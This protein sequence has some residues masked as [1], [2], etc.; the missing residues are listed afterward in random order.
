[1][2]AGNKETQA[3]I[4][5]RMRGIVSWLGAAPGLALLLG[6]AASAR[7]QF[8]TDAL[9][10]CAVSSSS[11]NGWFQSGAAGSGGLVMPANSVTF[12]NPANNNC[13]FYQWAERM[14]LWVTSPSPAGSPFGNGAAAN[15]IVFDSPTFYDVSPPDANGNRTLVGHPFT[16]ETFRFVEPRARKV[17]P[18]GL[19]I[20]KS[21]RGQ[22]L[23]LE[24]PRKGPAGKPLITDVSGKPVE[25]AQVRVAGSEV[26]LFDASGKAISLR[27]KTSPS[28]IAGHF[29]RVMSLGTICT[30]GA[31]CGGAGTGPVKGVIDVET[32]SII[33]TDTDQA[34]EG[35][36]IYPVVMTQNGSL[37]YYSI[38]VNDVFVN[39]L[40]G[41]NSHGIAP[42]PT[43]FPTT[44]PELNAITT[45]A[46]S[47]KQ[48]LADATA[49][50]VELKA[51]WVE[52]STLP[53]GAVANYI[54]TQASVPTY[55]KSTNVWT[56]TG[57]TENKSLALVGMHVVGSV[58]GHPEMIFA[59]FEHFG[60]APNAGYSYVST[61]KGANGKN[62]TT[63]VPQ[64][65]GGPWLLAAAGSTGPPF[66]PCILVEIPGVSIPW[67]CPY[68]TE[69]NGAI[70]SYAPFTIGSSNT[71]RL[72]PFGAASDTT[73]NHNATSPAASNSEVISVNSSVHNLMT[74]AGADPRNNYYLIGAEWSAGGHLPGQ[75]TGLP[76]NFFHSPP[77]TPGITSNVVGTSQLFNTTMETYDQGPGTVLYQGPNTGESCFDCHGG[78]LAMFKLSHIFGTINVTQVP[79]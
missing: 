11:F 60:N 52:A 14:F 54:T 3:L 53:T 45:F 13:P 18:H 63:S 5:T 8:P 20:L 36:G 71:L 9:P 6:A 79:R 1:M 17:G 29:T 56:P 32:G 31:S 24:T 7:A 16:Q 35:P 30:L 61:Q 39:L 78:S 26:T 48:V 55:T 44:Q 2:I 59:T 12:S 64:D 62:K 73:P 65:S 10:S 42:A 28:R 27:P 46:T 47:Q 33:E 37:I 67:N 70:R 41:T 21:R 75:S 57:K 50:A 69:V 77:N 22:A 34:Q 49:L 74:A 72:K 4:G 19:P 68:M 40:A 76:T 15:P 66:S 43:R 58:A 51:A 38:M 25:I 23:E